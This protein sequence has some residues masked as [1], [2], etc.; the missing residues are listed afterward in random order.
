MKRGGG[1]CSVGSHCGAESAGGVRQQCMRLCVTCMKAGV[2]VC[3]SV[4]M[5]ICLSDTVYSCILIRLFFSFMHTLVCVSFDLTNAPTGT[6]GGG[7]ALTT[8]MLGILSVSQRLHTN[9]HTHTGNVGFKPTQNFTHSHSHTHTLVVFNM[10]TFY[11]ATL[12][13]A[14]T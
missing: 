4:S 14:E 1:A 8:G 12:R 7:L 9:T 11:F 2:C 13:F 10:R 5:L 6:K 3:F